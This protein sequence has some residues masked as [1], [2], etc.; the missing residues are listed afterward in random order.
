M[1]ESNK[2]QKEQSPNTTAGRKGS[3]GSYS[4]FL[5]RQ[6]RNGNGSRWRGGSTWHLAEAAVPAQVDPEVKQM[7]TAA[8][9]TR[10]ARMR[11]GTGSALPRGPSQSTDLLCCE[12]LCF[13]LLQHFCHTTGEVLSNTGSSGLEAKQAMTC[14]QKGSKELHEN[15]GHT[16]LSQ[17]SASHTTSNTRRMIR[18]DC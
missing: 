16:Q 12:F 5:L 2:F 15:L 10:A 3:T 7:V 4:A 8:E 6:N 17:H 9:G 11:C 1:N 18:Q 13:I 14:E